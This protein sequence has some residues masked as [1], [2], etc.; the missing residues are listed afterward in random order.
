MPT[1]GPG[2]LETGV[3]EALTKAPVEPGGVC[4]RDLEGPDAGRIS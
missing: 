1:D 4:I 3:T 2:N